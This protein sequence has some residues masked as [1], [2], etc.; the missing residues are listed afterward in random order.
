MTALTDT[1]AYE[2]GSY[3]YYDS[4]VSYRS[5][6]VDDD[7][8]VYTLFSS[9]DYGFKKGEKTKLIRG[10]IKKHNEYTPRNSDKPIKQNLLTRA[11]F[12]ETESE[13]V[14]EDDCTTFTSLLSRLN[15][16]HS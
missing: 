5:S 1:V 9:S 12:S 4:G 2:R 16:L 14:N 8:N 13:Q 6:L 3:S 11:D 10:I 15:L 7:G